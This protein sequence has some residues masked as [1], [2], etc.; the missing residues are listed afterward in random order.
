MMRK[1]QFV[2][3]HRQI[4]EELRRKIALGEYPNGTKLPTGEELCRMFSVSRIT[5]GAVFEHLREAGL[6]RSVRHVGSFVCYEPEDDYFRKVQPHRKKTEIIHSLLLPTPAGLH[7]MELIANIF[8]QNNPEISIRFRELRPQDNK[9]IY[10][11]LRKSGDL[12]TCGE[13]FWHA[14]YA[15]YN[16]L[17]PLEP[18]PGFP[19][20]LKTLHTRFVYETEN[21]RSES[22][23][24]AL[25]L[26]LGVPIFM[27]LNLDICRKAEVE[28]KPPRKWSDLLKITK[29]L[30]ENKRSAYYFSAAL[31]I[32]NAFHGVKPWVEMLGQDLF[33]RGE[34]STNREI[35]HQIFNSPGA[36]SALKNIEMLMEHGR[37]RFK[38]GTEY[39]ALGDTALLPFT[40]NWAL[41]LIR[42]ITPD[43]NKLIFQPPPVGRNHIY[44]SFVS[45]FGVGL[46][47]QGIRS[48]EQKEA[49]WKW[50]RFL[51]HPQPQYLL[52]QEYRL[53]ARRDTRIY[54]AETDPELYKLCLQVLKNGVPQPDFVGM[55]Q[56]FAVAGKYLSQFLHHRLTPEECLKQIREDLSR[57]D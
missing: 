12:P 48:E 7:I 11:E 14:L 10:W 47:Q 17:C 39:Y 29:A 45:S 20:L 21:S 8:M 16:M 50:I 41:S 53:P 19:N 49:A 9:D 44:R 38:K 22:H 34:Q 31:N 43:M 36:L 28:V 55:R 42:M 3:R 25:P 5:I 26:F 46:F 23:I 18:L 6:I 4:F 13:F 27:S 1:K 56:D 35:F 2:A 33:V 40:T 15:K 32:P 30:G 24:H 52:S 37:I 57:H 51:F 54:L